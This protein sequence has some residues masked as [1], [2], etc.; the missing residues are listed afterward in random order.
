MLEFLDNIKMT[1]LVQAIIIIIPPSVVC[2]M[3]ADAIS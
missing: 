1:C 2:I 3:P